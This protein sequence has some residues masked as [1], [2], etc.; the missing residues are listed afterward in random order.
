MV[1]CHHDSCGREQRVWVPTSERKGSDVSLHPWC[2]K[3]GLIK[4]ISDDNS[5]KIGYW[6]NVLSTISKR[7]SLTQVQKRLVAKELESSNYFD[8]TYGSF[9]SAQKELFI[10][11]VRKHCNI[12]HNTIDSFIC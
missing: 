3:C 6:M 11:T 2:M 12:S 9:G 10:E 5:H 4:N 7:F 8:D 1:L